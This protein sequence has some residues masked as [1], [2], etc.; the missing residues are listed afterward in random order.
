MGVWC[1]DPKC[2]LVCPSHSFPPP[3]LR[4]TI[5][6]LMRVLAHLQDMVLTE[7]SGEMDSMHSMNAKF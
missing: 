1:R 4:P 7:C 3:T 2:R 5:L 6:Y